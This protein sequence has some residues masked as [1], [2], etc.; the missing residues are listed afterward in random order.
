MSFYEL[1]KYKAYILSSDRKKHLIK[2]RKKIKK[3]VKVQNL[4]NYLSL[5]I[6][7]PRQA[8]N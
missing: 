8:N 3:R 5:A 7:Y 2:L 6:F 1:A 4:I